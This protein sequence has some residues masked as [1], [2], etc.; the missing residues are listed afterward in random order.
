M[1]NAGTTIF[2]V[3]GDG[4]DANEKK[5]SDRGPRRVDENPDHWCCDL[6]GVGILRLAPLGDQ[7]PSPKSVVRRIEADLYVESVRLEIR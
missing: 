4:T 7:D 6:E 3:K 2:I 5:G 1:G